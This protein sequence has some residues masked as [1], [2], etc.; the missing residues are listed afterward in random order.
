MN[1]S[2]NH[3]WPYKRRTSIFSAIVILLSLLLI[4]VVLKETIQWPTEKNDTAILMGI[5]VFSLLPVLFVLIDVFLERGGVLQYGKFKIDLSHVSQMG[6]TNVTIPANIEEYG[7]LVNDSSQ[8]QILKTLE[9]A[10]T[11]D[12]AIID[13]DDGD[14]WLETRLLVLVA[15]ATRLAKP[16]KIVFISTVAGKKQRF[17]GWSHPHE[18]LPLLLK[19][20]RKYS[21]SYYQSMAAARQWELVEPDCLT[22]SH[23]PF[24][25]PSLAADY[26]NYYFDSAG[27]PNKVFAEL[28]LAMDLMDKVE[29]NKHPARIS[30]TRLKELFTPVLYKDNIDQNWPPEKQNKHF[31][32]SDADYLVITKNKKYLA[33]VSRLTVLSSILKTEVKQK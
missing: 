5:S 13:L 3:F 33:M 18:L 16:S 27:T 32:D 22:Q 24:S 30:I 17:Q 10:T 2:D 28:I 8:K 15:G 23:V 6:M 29:N 25:K 7:S 1:N 14:A 19:V 12:V 20:H 26:S 31:F 21:I 11:C 9:K 4:L